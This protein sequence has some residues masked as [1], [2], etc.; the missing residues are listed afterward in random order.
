MVPVSLEEQPVYA[1]TQDNREGVCID[2]A[3]A[4]RSDCEPILPAKFHPLSR[5][6][7]T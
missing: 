7:Y 1:L 4:G 5:L 6:I 3:T 2:V